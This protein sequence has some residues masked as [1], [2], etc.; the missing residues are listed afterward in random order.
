MENFEDERMFYDDMSLEQAIE[1]V[2][3]YYAYYIEED[4]HDYSF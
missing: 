3:D 4:Y 1:A 2:D